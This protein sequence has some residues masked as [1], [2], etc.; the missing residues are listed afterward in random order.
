MGWRF[1]PFEICIFPPL[2]LLPKFAR[3]WKWHSNDRILSTLLKTFRSTFKCNLMSINLNCNGSFGR[4]RRRSIDDYCWIDCQLELMLIDDQWLKTSTTLLFCLFERMSRG[5]MA[6][7]YFLHFPFYYLLF[8]V[9]Y[10][11]FIFDYLLS[12]RMWWVLLFCGR[13][14]ETSAND[15]VLAE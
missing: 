13:A 3:V 1:F 7:V 6:A 2:D 15:D 14:D 10:F 9:Y 11:V 8:I 12:R 4:N 5:N